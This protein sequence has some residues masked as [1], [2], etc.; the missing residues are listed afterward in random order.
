MAVEEERKIGKK[1]SYEFKLGRIF[2]LEQGLLEVVAY[3]FN[4]GF[5]IF[6]FDFFNFESAVNIVLKPLFLLG[7]S[8]K[9]LFGNVFFCGASAIFFFLFSEQH[10]A[11]SQILVN[12]L[13]HEKSYGARFNFFAHLLHI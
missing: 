12:L 13:Y 11:T 5:A 1:C 3:I 8:F 4:Y 6:I 9:I 7:S 10:F 2:A